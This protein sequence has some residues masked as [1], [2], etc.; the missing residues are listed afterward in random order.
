MVLSFVPSG[1]KFVWDFVPELKLWAIFNL[2]VDDTE[3][4]PPF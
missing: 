4:V 2:I 1:L 3:V